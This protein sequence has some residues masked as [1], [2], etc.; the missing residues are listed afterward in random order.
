[1]PERS[2][3]KQELAGELAELRR[4]LTELLAEEPDLMA[5]VERLLDSE[6]MYRTLV[7]TSPDAVTAT[8]LEG[9]I[10]Y[11]SEK[12]LELH[13][14][15]RAEE[16]IGKSSLDFIAPEDHARAVDGI[17]K[18]MEKGST[19]LR[20]Y[21]LFRKDGTSFIGE[22]SASL[23]KDAEGNPKAFIGIVRDVSERSRMEEALRASEEKYRDLVENAKDAIYSLDRDG[24]ITYMSP[25][26]EF[27]SGYKPSD[28]VGR[29]FHNFINEDDLPA[30]HDNFRAALAGKEAPS[31]FRFTKPTGEVR[32]ARSSGKPMYEGDRI[33]GV[34]GV[35]SDITDRKNAE[36]E[37]QFLGSI[38][39]QAKDAFIVTDLD[40]KITY[41]NNA[42]EELFG[43]ALDDLRGETPGV[44]NAEADSDKMQEEIYK[45]VQSGGVWNGTVLNKRKDGGTFLCE[46]KV[47]PIRDERGRVKS[48]LGIQR[49]ITEKR[50][51]QEQLLQAQKMEAVG[52]LAGGI[53]HDFNN[54]LTAIIGYSDLLLAGCG[55]DFEL[56]QDIRE[57]GSVARRAAGLTRQLLSFSRRQIIK[58]SPIDLSVQVTRLENMLRRLLGESVELSIEAPPGLQAI[59]ADAGQI[60]Q[61]IMNLVLN[62][63]DAMPDGGR[64]TVKVEAVT[65]DEESC[66]GIQDAKPGKWIRLSVADTGPGIEEDVLRHIF[67]PFFTTKAVGKG[68]GLGL[69]VV[70]GIVQQHEGW[71]DVRT[72]RGEGTVFRVCF[73]AVV[74]LP[75]ERVDEDAIEADLRG[76]GE[77]ILVVEDEEGVRSFAARALASRGYVVFEAA[78]AREAESVFDSEEGK[79][80]LILCDV[81]LPDGN[82]LELAER[83]SSRSGGVP[84]LLTSGYADRSLR[85]SMIQRKGI[86][87]LCKPYEFADLLRAVKRVLDA[88]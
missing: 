56:R 52:T 15:E 82:G 65:L 67:E 24:V 3:T 10:T 13:G 69:S 66:K 6:E 88:D 1:M 32:W 64:I 53:A 72:E 70:Y 74:D 78:D 14:F 46:M 73:P 31:E 5:A 29:P 35:L 83:L 77:R 39:S 55:R 43:Y 41:M 48:Y 7:R 17:R 21:T 4:R 12:T 30:T 37:A 20:R 81:V 59:K 40:F 2:K 58:V 19:S 50:Q 60:E 28:L 84:M 75:E 63:G 27:I 38:A 87:F 45:T 51:L 61:V 33:V 36:Q 79:F 22:L 85:W 71:I 16:M 34:R 11:V 76:K 26:V 54:M 23:I 57:I 42:A 18:T 80:A 44:L 9:R 86:E 47:G 68:T 8:D 49:D 62:A 25:S